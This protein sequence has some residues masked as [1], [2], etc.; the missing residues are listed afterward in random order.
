MCSRQR[1][2]TALDPTY[3]HNPLDF[4]VPNRLSDASIIYILKGRVQSQTHTK[5]SFTRSYWFRIIIFHSNQADE[6]TS[7][8]NENSVRLDGS[9]VGRREL[10]YIQYF[11]HRLVDRFKFSLI[12]W[13]LAYSHFEAFR[14]YPYW[15]SQLIQTTF[16]M[17]L[18]IKCI[19]QANQRTESTLFLVHE[20]DQTC[21]RFNSI[22]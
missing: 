10:T 2:I 8:G 11:I 12:S 9:S 6:R 13:F 15:G 21:I 4:S 22:Q 14:L 18:P 7:L 3:S 17:F 16:R 20:R 5:I 19:M 1:V